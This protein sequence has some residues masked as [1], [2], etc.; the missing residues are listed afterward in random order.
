MNTTPDG[1]DFLPY[2]ITYN[3]LSVD[4]V[5]TYENGEE[6]I[7]VIKDRDGAKYPEN[8]RL[9]EKWYIKRLK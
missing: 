1:K 5:V 4:E 9:D 6:M 2:C 8:G 7:E 3:L